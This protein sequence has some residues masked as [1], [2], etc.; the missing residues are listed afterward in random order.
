MSVHYFGK[1]IDGTMAR[2]FGNFSDDEFEEIIQQIGGILPKEWK[3][4]HFE[5]NED[6]TNSKRVQAFAKLPEIKI[7]HWSGGYY[8]IPREQV[9]EMLRGESKKTSETNKS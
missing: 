9:A 6:I 5:E 1:K 4:W 2:F 7:W 8:S 3:A